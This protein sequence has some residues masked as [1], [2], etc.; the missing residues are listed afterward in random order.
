MSFRNPSYVVLPRLTRCLSTAPDSPLPTI[1]IGPMKTDLFRDIPPADLPFCEPGPFVR[2]NAYGTQLI[3]RPSLYVKSMDGPSFASSAITTCS[4]PLQP[5]SPHPTSFLSHHRPRSLGLGTTHSDHQ[6]A[7]DKVDIFTP[8]GTAKD[9]PDMAQGYCAHNP[10]S[11]AV[12]PP[13]NVYHPS[14]VRPT[15]T[16]PS[17]MK[18]L[19]MR[20]PKDDS[21][22]LSRSSN[23]PVT[24]GEFEWKTPTNRQLGERGL[25]YDDRDADERRIRGSPIPL[26]SRTRRI[27]P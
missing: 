19:S 11:V 25:L 21:P 1:L 6:L 7:H 10:R 12:W 14:P 2:T 8:Q 3:R 27:S 18:S 20:N 23:A 9:T 13:N 17:L 4:S 26:V 15:D 5:P 22:S 24:P 16:I